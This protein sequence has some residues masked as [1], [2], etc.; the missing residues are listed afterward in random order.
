MLNKITSLMLIMCL[1][2]YVV[3]SEQIV[4]TQPLNQS[5]SAGQALSFDVVYST[6]NPVNNSLTGLGL[7]L[8]WDSSVLTF[9]SISNLFTR[10]MLAQGIPESDTLNLD[11]DSN[12][13]MYIN[14]AWAD[15]SGNWPGEESSIILYRANFSKNDG[16]NSNTTINFSSSSNAAGYTLDATSN[17]ISKGIYQ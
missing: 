3:A 16:I 2:S 9:K 15:F 13:D 4:T 10:N 7:R 8:H 11:G 6:A 12:T 1:S 17:I 14:I 5:A